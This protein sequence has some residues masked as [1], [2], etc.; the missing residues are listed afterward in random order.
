[1]TTDPV[2]EARDELVWRKLGAA[3]LFFPYAGAACA[4]WAGRR[5]RRF[6]VLS[7]LRLRALWSRAPLSLS[8]AGDL[9]L[10]RGVKIAVRPKERNELTIG[11]SCV[12]GDGVR[13]E[14]RG[15]SLRL[16]QKVDLRHGCVLGVEGVLEFEGDNMVQH[17]AT[18]HC[19]ESIRLRR[20]SVLSEYATVV[21]S[22]HT[23]D[24]PHDWW[25]H[26]VETAPVLI[27]EEVW[28]AA[29]STI[30]RG[31]RIGRRAVIGANSVV[32]KD[33]PDGYLASGVPAKVLRPVRG[34]LSSSSALGPATVLPEAALS[35]PEGLLPS[36]SS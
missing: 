30:S 4:F 36:S 7:T 3:V 34:A 17:G 27:E 1:M 18:F 11:R 24:G 15:G 19:D 23:Y 33:V 9:R 22:S 5:L 6:R 25:L 26:N 12:I 2:P 20:G 14:L 29:K 10:G 32:V 31:V 13:I 28:V 8:V 35:W 16:G 21:D